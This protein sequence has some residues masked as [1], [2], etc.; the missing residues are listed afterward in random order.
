MVRT[1]A[2]GVRP[3]DKSIQS[4]AAA[5]NPIMVDTNVCA[6][7]KSKGTTNAVPAGAS[8]VGQQELRYGHS[9]SGE[10]TTSTAATTT[11]TSNRHNQHHPAA[12]AAA[13]HCGSANEGSWHCMPSTPI[14]FGAVSEEDLTALTET[15]T[16]NVRFSNR[17]QCMPATYTSQ[18]QSVLVGSSS[19]NIRAGGGGSDVTATRINAVSNRSCAP[20]DNVQDDQ[21]AAFVEQQSCAFPS[22]QRGAQNCS[23][24]SYAEQVIQSQVSACAE[25]AANS[26]GH[27][28]H[29]VSDSQQHHAPCQ[30]L[31]QPPLHSESYS[32]FLHNT[33]QHD[34][35]TTR[36]IELLSQ[37]RSPVYVDVLPVEGSPYNHQ[38]TYLEDSIAGAGNSHGTDH[39]TQPNHDYTG[40]YQGSLSANQQRQP[41]S[42]CGN[43]ELRQQRNNVNPE[44]AA[45]DFVDGH[46]I[47]QMSS[48]VPPEGL[49]YYM[50]ADRRSSNGES[51]V[52]GSQLRVGHECNS[53]G[54]YADDNNPNNFRRPCSHPGAVPSRVDG[55]S[56]ATAPC[57]APSGIATHGVMSWHS[58]LHPS[59]EY[60]MNALDC[61]LQ[62]PHCSN[63]GH[64]HEEYEGYQDSSTYMCPSYNQQPPQDTQV[65]YG[66]GHGQYQYHD[67]KVV[68]GDCRDDFAQGIAAV[69]DIAAASTIYNT[70][71]VQLQQHEQDMNT[72]NYNAVLRS[73]SMV[74]L[75]SLA[76]PSEHN[77]ANSSAGNTGL[78]CDA[79]G[80]HCDVYPHDSSEQRYT[81]T[82]E[83][84]DHTNPSA[85]FSQDEQQYTSAA[86]G[87]PQP[88]HLHTSFDGQHPVL[89]QQQN[90]VSFATVAASGPHAR[91]HHRAHSHTAAA[92]HYPTTHIAPA[93]I[94]STASVHQPTAL[95]NIPI[96]PTPIRLPNE[97]W[98][99]RWMASNLKRP[100]PPITGKQGVL[101][102]LPSPPP[103]VFVP[104]QLYRR[105]YHGPQTA[106][107]QNQYQHYH[108]QQHSVQQQQHSVQ[109][110]QHSVQQQQ[111]SV[112]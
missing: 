14:I 19:D 68:N 3:R 9:S 34:L 13:F 31:H 52:I 67:S 87:V 107:Y 89:Q 111:H 8:H 10:V 69:E 64:I 109:Q 112:Q 44:A 99:H 45:V 7:T 72:T 20:V 77:S 2:A 102:Y 103:V 82:T 22:Q 41:N 101:P 27:I 47:Y 17:Q 40:H 39:S 73:N 28:Q 23:H 61:N 66:S 12:A 74:H 105:Q 62:L 56:S 86:A 85:E 15:A 80:R 37:Q 70:N 78:I 42:G 49:P 11:G 36:P 98:T 53:S 91:S 100:A 5:V 30:S 57:S 55:R 16:T 84:L 93:Y 90:T 110:Q 96:L 48:Q 6:G 95:N 35:C 29:V 104:R 58:G 92:P 97:E 71:E 38:P 32:P 4:T 88:H 43:T 60:C 24:F 81:N 46:G 83:V 76:A 51:V 54:G 25:P 18:P 94:P 106:L 65:M 1:P 63:G 50:A 26:M 75:S 108:Q 59:P 33:T 79:E 21:H